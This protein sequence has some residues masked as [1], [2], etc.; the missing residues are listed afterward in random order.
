MDA[1]STPRPPLII[2]RDA[3]RATDPHCARLAATDLR[4]VADAAE[5]TTSLTPADPKDE[6][7]AGLRRWRGDA[8]GG[9]TVRE[10]ATG[11]GTSTRVRWVITTGKTIGR[12]RRPPAVDVVPPRTEDGST[13]EP[14]A[15]LLRALAP[16]M[17]AAADVVDGAT[18]GLAAET[19]NAALWIIAERDPAIAA[20]PGMAS[21]DTTHRA[22]SPFG[23]ER[24]ETI[25]Y[26]VG[27]MLAADQTRTVHAPPG[28]PAAMSVELDA[29][30]RTATLR[31]PVGHRDGASLDAYARRDP[32]LIMRTVA[33]LTDP[34][35]GDHP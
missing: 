23:P 28:L 8:P 15:E 9:P 11:F 24:V 21:H 13:P 16:W 32:V 12:R 10:V 29:A 33:F 17:R 6:G 4:H 14:T 2:R 20:T 25:H 35:G 3:D 27:G 30:G 7:V 31:V 22:A 18:P 5:R 34:D 1:V 26:A 19:W